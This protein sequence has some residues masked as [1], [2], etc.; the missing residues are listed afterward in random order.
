VRRAGAE[1]HRAKF[2]QHDGTQDSHGTPTYRVPGD[3]DT[4]VAAWPCE[5]LTSTGT[6][7]LRGKQVQATTTHVLFGEYHGAKLVEPDMR[8]V[9]DNV[10]YGVVAAFDPMGNSREIRIELKRDVE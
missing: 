10:T 9:I 8:A 6:E 2:T 5:L 7:T 3:W 1:R 4:V